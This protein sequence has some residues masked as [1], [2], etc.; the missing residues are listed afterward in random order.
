LNHKRKRKNERSIETNENNINIE[1]EEGEE[2]GD[3]K[4]IFH[5]QKNER[6]K[7][8]IKNY[9][10]CNSDKKKKILVEKRKVLGK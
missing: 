10:D 8:N 3:K 2:K 7:K 5:L 1:E 4:V 6:G 9:K